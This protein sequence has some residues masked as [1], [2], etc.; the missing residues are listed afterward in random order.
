LEEKK[1]LNEPITLMLL[2]GALRFPAYIGAFAAIEEKGLKID[3]II[4]ASAGSIIGSIYASGKSPLEMKKIMMELDTTIFK[5]FSIKSLL[6]GKGLY[7]GKVFEKWVDGMLKGLK[8]EDK[9]RFPLYI[10]AF[11]ILNNTPVIFSRSSFPEM[12]I[13]AAIRF[14]IGIPW[15]FAYKYFTHT[16]KRHVFV[17]GNLM[18]GLVEDMFEKDNRMLVLR[19]HSKKS[20]APPTHENFTLRKYLQELLLIMM[21]AVESERV[22]AD[23][24]KDTILIFCG[25]IPPTKFGISSEEKHYLFDQGYI[26]VKKFLEYKWGI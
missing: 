25:D 13:S 14:S 8:F 21:H 3:K 5:D 19:I 26:Q 10:A 17:D 6:R 23:R 15:V 18:S 20:A 7:E 16:K 12:K 2:G 24:W 9:L 1:L 22:K 11:D 4:G